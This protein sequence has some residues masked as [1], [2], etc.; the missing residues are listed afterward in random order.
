MT[1]SW[2]GTATYNNNNINKGLE[3]YTVLKLSILL[4]K[5][6]TTLIISVGYTCIYSLKTFSFWQNKVADNQ[7][8]VTV[9]LPS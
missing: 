4:T 5:F 3:I 8:P 9:M 2:Q 1:Y 6:V 7:K